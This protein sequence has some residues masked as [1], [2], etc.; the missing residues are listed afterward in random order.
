MKKSLMWCFVVAMGVTAESSLASSAA[1]P[2]AR[3]IAAQESAPQEQAAAKES[4]AIQPTIG[5]SGPEPAPAIAPFDAEQA[6][7]HQE[8]WAEHLGVPVEVTNSIGMKLVLIPPGE[9][10]TGIPVP[11]LEAIR[12]R[13]PITKPFHFGVQ[14]V[15]QE[16][17]E[18]VMGT[19]PSGIK[20]PQHPVERVSWDEAVTFCDKLSALPEEKAAGRVYRLPTDAEWEYACRAGSTTRFSF[21]DDNAGLGDHG[22][23][24]DNSSSTTHPVGE[25]RPN[26]WGLYDMH[27]NVCE[28]SVGSYHENRV[29]RGGGW[30]FPATYCQSASCRWYQ[31]STRGSDLGFRVTAAL[32]AG[33]ASGTKS[34]RQ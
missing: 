1:E 2:V 20:G 11:D 6:K 30:C 26:A 14:E 4:A 18:R 22:W 8:A 25:K 3:P 10:M 13:M 16:Q 32:S 5:R 9:F 7:R 19:N 33:T 34:D 24:N 12:F 29:L 15:T 23:F 17:Y 28:W 31:P 27:G 21:G